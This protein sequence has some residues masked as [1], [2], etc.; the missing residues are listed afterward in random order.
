MAGNYLIRGQKRILSIMLVLALVFGSM[1]MAATGIITVYAADPGD[2]VTVRIEGNGYGTD[3]TSNGIGTILDE[4]LV[5]LGNLANPSKAIDAINWALESKGLAKAVLADESG[6]FAP[7]SF[8]GVTYMGGYDWNFIFNDA[9]AQNGIKGQE[10]KAGDSIVMNL[11]ANYA[12]GKYCT[13][14]Y[15]SYFTEKSSYFDGTY[16]PYTEVGLILKRIIPADWVTT[17]TEKVEIVGDADV[18][19]TAAEGNKYNYTC[20]EKTDSEN[21]ILNFSAWGTGEYIISATKTV[22]GKNTISRPYCKITLTGDAVIV[23]PI[24][25]ASDTSVKSL[26]LTFGALPAIDGKGYLNGEGLSVNNAVT[27]VKLSAEA[28]DVKSSVT[29]N[30][31]PA[32]G[33]FSEYDLASI[34]GIDLA[35][36][37]N[38]FK[39]TVANGTDTQIHTLIIIRTPETARNIPAEVSAVINGVKSVKGF[40]PINDWILAMN[41]AG[42]EVSAA[43]KQEYLAAVLPLIDNF[44]DTGAGSVGS[45]AKI[46]IALSSMGIDVRQIADPDGGDAPIN[47]MASIAN[48]DKPVDQYSALPIL[49]LYDL[50]NSSGSSSYVLPESPKVTRDSLVTTILATKDIDTGLF[51]S[52]DYTGMAMPALSPYYLAEAAGLNGVDTSTVKASV[53]AAVNGL[54]QKQSIDGGFGSRNSNTTA[55]VITGLAALKI[56]PHTDSR[57]IKS[58]SSLITD[59]LSFRTAD[60][61]LGYTSNASSNDFASL[62][63]FQALAAYRNLTGATNSNIYGFKADV[64][65]YTNWPAAEL[66]TSIAVTKLP[67]TTIYS[68]SE[69]GAATEVNTAGLE[70]TAYYNGSLLNSKKLESGYTVSKID[71]TAAGTK[72]VTVTYQGQT[73]TF[74]VTVK[75]SGGSV[76]LEKTVK[77]TVRGSGKSVIASNNAYVIESGKTTVMD[78]LKAVLSE[79]G[80]AY[81]VQG[82][83]YVS[84]IDGLGEFSS[85]SNSGWMYYVNGI[86]PVKAANLYKLSGNEDILWTYTQDYTK[87]SGAEKWNQAMQIPATGEITR[88]SLNAIVKEINSGKRDSWSVELAQGKITFDKEALIGLADQMDKAPLEISI[89]GISSE[90]LSAKQREAAGSRPVYDISVTSG[91]KK[92]S[93][94][95]G[96][97][98]IALP[99]KLKEG[100]SPS[101]IVVYHLNAEGNLLPMKGSYD[102]VSGNV[103]FMVDHLSYYVIGYDEALAKWPFAD[104]AQ[105]KGLNWFYEPVKFVYERGIFSGTSAGTFSPNSPLTRSMLASVLARMSGADLTDYKTVPF[106]DVD[107]NSW[108][109][110]SV[111]WAKEAGIV[112]GYAGKDGRFTFKP[113]DKISRQDIAVM[114]NNYNEK[115]AKKAYNQTDSAVT[116][117]DH[118]QIAEYAKAAVGS[119]Q[120]AGIIK[121]MKNDDGS[122]RFQPINNATRAE[123]ATMIYNMIIN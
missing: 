65:V 31:K 11:T 3:G 96:K 17:F 122:F 79:A 1:G 18:I 105:D 27:A 30:Y 121:G 90:K 55:T 60:D 99:Y 70:V 114:L 71:T 16:G 9:G 97:L 106:T 73:A 44:A 45:M 112:S 95:G 5:P 68:L 116:F 102:P 28:T 23:S 63:G 46:A 6:W 59:L 43:D 53:N 113:D 58:G 66:L 91:K 98:T 82:G 69:G 81:V 50:K 26:Q 100:E 110:P 62:Q 80:K 40:Q 87:E 42:L 67:D 109:G 41:A 29:V 22:E 103:I 39:I 51:G 120:K 21:G 72:S 74:N 35:V 34:N 49:S 115:A 2:Y 78:V 37:E 7:I 85:G 38:T 84:E 93:Q 118:G 75:D 57:F 12:S 104:V 107:I 89:D 32:G 36:G 111:A 123:A 76:P 20:S 119:M 54:S 48:Y 61:K 25:K 88:D 83:A 24:S 8:G 10:I 56:N 47:L 14:P 13:D 117:T 86:D 4:T 94:F 92:V 64:N 108:Y 15:Y 77:I 101:G 33:S 52:V 19:V